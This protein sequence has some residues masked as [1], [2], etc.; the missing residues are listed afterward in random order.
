MRRWQCCRVHRNTT[1]ETPAI[2]S[3]WCYWSLSLRFQRRNG[4]AGTHQRQLLF[5]LRNANL[6]C[7]LLL[8]ST[9][10]RA[11]WSSSNSGISG[12]SLEAPPP[13]LNS[14]SLTYSHNA[15]ITLPA[16][17]P[18]PPPPPP[19]PPIAEWTRRVNPPSYARKH[20]P[21][22]GSSDAGAPKTTACEKAAHTIPTGAVRPFALLPSA[23]AS[24]TSGLL[25]SSDDVRASCIL[26]GSCIAHSR[27]QAR[28]TA[29]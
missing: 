2:S 11:L 14:P 12:K 17:C 25:A 20:P 18:P 29:T 27:R 23:C 15:F 9:R 7:C 13:S 10:Q 22:A 1:P 28:F 5:T 26:P 3:A 6:V 4:T 19:A 24:A 21:S 8:P 16:P